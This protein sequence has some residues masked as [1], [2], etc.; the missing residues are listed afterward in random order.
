MSAPFDARQIANWFLTRAK[1]DANVLSVTTLL[2]LCYIA[3]GWHLELLGGPLFNNRIE[4]WRVGPIILDVN[5]AFVKQ[6]MKVTKLAKIQESPFDPRIERFLEKVYSVY[7]G[8]SWI[9]LSG[10]TLISG[11]PWD[12]AKRIGGYYAEI[13]DDLIKQHYT[14]KSAKSKEAA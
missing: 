12:I 11:G 3:H 7:G 5:D 6:G 2:K 1:Q 14:L 9:D 8:R 13:P 10:L 4:A